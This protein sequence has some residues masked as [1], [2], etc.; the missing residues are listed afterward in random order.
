MNLQT[1][2]LGIALL[3]ERTEMQQGGEEVHVIVTN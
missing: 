3:G 2:S 1:L